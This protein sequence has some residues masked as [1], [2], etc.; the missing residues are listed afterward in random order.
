[1]LL[2]FL[3]EMVIGI[4][5]STLGTRSMDLVSTALPMATATKA[6]G[7]KARSKDLGCTH[8][9]TATSDRGTGIQGL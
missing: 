6:P 4:L 9:A 3:S 1:M 5:G 8:S 7:M 2:K